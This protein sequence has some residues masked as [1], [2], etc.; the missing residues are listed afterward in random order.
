MFSIV[1]HAKW[2]RV[3]S[4]GAAALNLR[5]REVKLFDQFIPEAVATIQEDDQPKDRTTCFKH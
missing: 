4:S 5:V 3:D 2:C 1:Y